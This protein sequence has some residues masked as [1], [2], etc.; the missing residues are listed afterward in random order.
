MTIAAFSETF[1]TKDS[2]CDLDGYRL[3]S[4]AF[5]I[6]NDGQFGGAAQFFDQIM[7]QSV[8]SSI[9]M[10]KIKGFQASIVALKDEIKI[11]CFYR[12]PNQLREDFTKTVNWFRENMTTKTIAIGDLN[13]HCNWNDFKAHKAEQQ[14]FVDLLPEKIWFQM[15]NQPT[16]RLGGLLDVLIT[17]SPELVASI[18][19]DEE[20]E[21]SDHFVL[22]VE[23]DIT[24]EEE[25]PFEVTLHDK[26]DIE[27]YLRALQAYDWNTLDLSDVEICFEQIRSTIVNTYDSIVKKKLIYPGRPRRQ[28]QSETLRSIKSVRLLRRQ[29]DTEALRKE[30]T[31]LQTLLRREKEAKIKRFLNK[32]QGPNG[33]LFKALK[34]RK[35][36]SESISRIQRPDGTFTSDEKEVADILGAFYASVYNAQQPPNVN[37]EVD[38]STLVGDISVTQQEIVIALASMKTSHG[39]GPDN[40][41]N[42]MLK[43]GAPVLVH[44]IQML[45]QVIITTGKHPKIWKRSHIRPRPKISNPTLPQHTRPINETSSLGKLLE[46][47]VLGRITQALERSGFYDS[48]QYGFRA[49]KNTS[50]NLLHYVEELAIML[51][52]TDSVS[53]VYYDFKS[54]FDLCAHHIVL[55]KLKHAGISGQTGRLIE[56]WLYGRSHVVIIGECRSEEFAVS[57]GTIQGSSYAAQLFLVYINDM[58]PRLKNTKCLLFADDLKM[59]RPIKNNYDALLMQIDIN[60]ATRWADQNEMI[61]NASKTHVIHFGTANFKPTLH[62]NNVIIQETETVKDLGIQF[63][64]TL[65]FQSHID[66]IT[67]RAFALAVALR[68]LLKHANWHTNKTETFSQKTPGRIIN[69]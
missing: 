17:G 33:N 23:L 67:S 9:E 12:S 62:L 11:M 10:N 65:S 49:M 31:K 68:K 30:K 7:S 61:F 36:G 63:T 35:V 13:L 24:P 4:N 25:K 47:V 28:F 19:V 42:A 39:T 45:F 59:F 37:W 32:V 2:Y 5:K 3:I 20:F 22:N 6:E 29:G 40:I 8:V 46:R 66:T 53:A 54:A 14:E 18:T 27:A 69:F 58:I 38:D 55:E 26:L 64:R 51:S 15:I 43:K 16:H 56:D 60:K 21:L 52:E 50:M 48:H 44:P 1:F 34:K 41:S 57:S